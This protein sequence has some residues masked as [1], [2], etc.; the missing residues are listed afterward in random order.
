[1]G[2]LHLRESDVCQLLTMD[3]AIDAVRDGFRRLADAS[4]MNVSRHRA[5]TPQVVLHTMSAASG[6]YRGIGFKAY[7]TGRSGNRFHFFLYDGESGRLDAIIEADW[8]GRIRTGAASAVASEC[9]ARL[10]SS[11]LG[12]I[13]T[14][15]QARTQMQA[16][17]C[18]R[19]IREV[20]VY[21]RDQERRDQFAREMEALCR[22]SVVPVSRPEDAAIDMDIVVTATNS[23]EPVL[24][25]AWLAEG[26]HINAMG[27]NALNR[28]ELDVDVIRRC[29]NIVTDSVE[30]CHLE[31]GDFAAALEQGILDWSR[32]KELSDVVAGAQ[33]GRATSESVTLFKSLGVAIEDLAVATRV[34]SLARERGVGVEVAV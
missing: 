11:Q 30:Q 8:L 20:R 9:M 24:R 7:T 22:V 18:V 14:G 23:R 16:I 6:A 29:D 33:L 1:M 13:G 3:L 26:T 34:V 2:T 5:R 28:A 19:T 4:A 10:E 27:S 12:I 25:G 32:V 15:G 17:C 21:G 31:A